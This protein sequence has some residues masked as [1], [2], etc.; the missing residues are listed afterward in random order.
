MRKQKT[1]KGESSLSGIGLHTGESVEL[2]F[3]PAKEDTG[4]LFRRTDISGTPEIPATVEYVQDT[5]RSTNIGIGDVRIHTIEHVLAAVRSCEIDN[6]IIEVSGSEPPVGDGSSA[7]FLEMIEEAGIT[8]QSSEK[9]VV[10][11][12]H[13]VYLSDGH[14]HMVA[15]PSADYRI[16]YTLHYPE[17]EAIR[18][19]YFSS[20]INQKIFKEEIGT[21]RTFS[22]YE[23][24]SFLIDRGLIKGGSLD[25]AV[26]VKDDVILSKE[27]LRF[28]DEMVRHKVLDLIGDLSLVGVP[29]NAHIIAIRSGHKSNV[30]LAKKLY[31]QITMENS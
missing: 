24:I 6:L 21:C 2:R 18:S 11:L 14:V 29:F 19:Q 23:E 8:E 1:L 7:P 4:V 28:P 25:N 27:G 13:P 3:C 17:A 20:V 12:K 31:N 10:S 9:S 16:S 15:L 26:V 5:S 30:A 22:L